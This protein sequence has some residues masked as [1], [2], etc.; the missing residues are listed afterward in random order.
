MA[1]F[2]FQKPGF[3]AGQVS[4]K[5]LGR[6]DMPQYPFA[7][8][9]MTNFIATKQ[10]PALGRPGS[11]FVQPVHGGETIVRL[12]PFIFSKTE[13]Y[14]I[15]ITPGSI[16][17]TNTATRNTTTVYLS[18]TY[19]SNELTEVQYTQSADTLYLVHPNHPPFTVVRTAVDTFQTAQFPSIIGTLIPNNLQVKQ[20]P[21]RDS[22]IDTTKTLT[23]SATTGTITVT[24]STSIF[25]SGHVGTIWKM[26]VGSTT[27]AFIIQSY[28]SGTS[29]TAGILNTLGGTT[30]TSDWEEP[31]WSYYRGWPRTV[32]FF[33]GRIVYG[34]SPSYPDTIWAS[35]A[36]DY[37]HLMAKKFVQDTST[38]TSGLKYFGAAAASDPAVFTL[39]SQQ[40]NS[41]QWMSPGKSL[42]IGTLG[43]EYVGAA[44]VGNDV[45]VF[46]A[47]SAHGSN[48]VQAKRSAYTVEYVRRSGRSL[49]EMQFDFQAQSYVSKDLSAFAYHN[50]I[51]QM[52]WQ[53]SMQVLWC[54]DSSGVLFGMTRDHDQ[55]VSAWH[56]RQMGGS[57]KDANGNVVP[58]QVLSVCCAPSNDGQYDDVWVAVHRFV[59]GSH[60]YH[61]ET[62]GREYTYSSL[63]PY[64]TI[65]LSVFDAPYFMDAASYFNSFGSPTN[66]VSGLTWLAGQ[67]VNVLADGTPITGLV[68]DSS[69]NL[70]LPA[71]YTRIIVGLPYAPRLKPVRP[72]AGA[73]LGSA[74]GAKK[75]IDRAVIRFNR[76]VGAAVGRDYSNLQEINF[77]DASLPMNAP[78]PPFTG[79]QIV[80][81]NGTFDTDGYFC[82]QQNTPGPITVVS[83][84]VRGEANES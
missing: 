64:P 62:F 26:T 21:F 7:C 32:C 11:C 54:V 55:Q 58:P 59:N 10:G 44:I 41:I 15:A 31:A 30:A 5:A 80:E 74:Q 75:R 84:S 46:S 22:N 36:L 23:A 76:T 61:I 47:E 14:V 67:T 66:T 1:K 56:Y 50:P 39:A 83:I 43:A 40:V 2:N 63:D 38:D 6:T 37:T 12:I 81:F 51:T 73:V 3:L 16:Q 25:N 65:A 19:A 52:D 78:I 20:Y 34:G 49:M 57:S 71:N 60:V 8:E 82:I 53:E 4:P 29:V 72:D 48:Y 70:T 45:N 79:D 68:V 35:K 9:E 17:A 24:A 18:S 33:N 27:G 77:R 42:A 28:T 69:G 13:S